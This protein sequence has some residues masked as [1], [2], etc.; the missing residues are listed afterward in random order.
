MENIGFNPDENTDLQEEIPKRP[1][2]LTVLIVLT[3][4]SIFFGLL[5]GVSSFMNGPLTEEQVEEGMMPLYETIPT[6]ESEGL[7]NYADMVRLIIDYTKHVND[8]SFSLNNLL[9]ILTYI[10]GI[11]AIVMMF[12]LRKIG[13]HLYVIY[14]LLPV[15]TLYLVAPSSLIPN[16]YVIFYMVV[17]ILFTLLYALNLKYMK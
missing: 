17:A 11:G 8:N 14:S 12:R 15:V 7:D 6:L 2:F 3:S 16:I 1:V 5:G 13:F 4:I 10:I 9:T